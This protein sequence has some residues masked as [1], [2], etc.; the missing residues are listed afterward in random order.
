MCIATPVPA[1]RWWLL[2]RYRI[3]DVARKVVGVGSVGLGCWVL[4][5][6]GLDDRDP[7]FLQVKE[8]RESVLA[9]YLGRRSA[10][11]H[12]GRRVVVGQRMIQGSPDILLGPV[13][14]RT[15]L[16]SALRDSIAA[17]V[18]GLEREAPDGF[19]ALRSGWVEAR[20]ADAMIAASDAT[21]D[22]VRRMFGDPQVTAALIE[23]FAR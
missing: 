13:A 9:P 8:A 18:I 17:A 14:V 19:A 15:S 4:L 12:Q 2:S 10:P 20:L 1:E 22:P 3:V 21:Y 16:P 11:I 6:E 5:L 7:L 23:R